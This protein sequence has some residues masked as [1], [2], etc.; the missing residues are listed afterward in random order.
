M[1]LAAG[2]QEALVSRLSESFAW[3]LGR[4]RRSGLS[5]LLVG[6]DVETAGVLQ[7]QLRRCGFSRFTAFASP[8]GVLENSGPNIDF[9]MILVDFD[10]FNDVDDGIEGLFDLRAHA[11]ELPVII[12]SSRVAGDDYGRER[13]SICDATLRKPV[14]GR[15]MATAVETVIQ[16]FGNGNRY[17]C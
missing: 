10:K 5:A 16:G 2:L 6:L 7:A 15:R 14:S 17:A 11:P 8:R 4:R 9:D 3:H 1:N 12:V 13:R